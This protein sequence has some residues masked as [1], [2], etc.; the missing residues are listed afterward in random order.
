MTGGVARRRLLAA[1]G[2]ALGAPSLAFGQRGQG[3]SASCDVL[4]AGGGGA[5]LAAAVSAAQEGAR[6]ILIEKLGALGGDTMRSSGYISAVVPRL[7]AA[8]GIEDSVELHAE[9]TLKA[10]GGFCDPRIV[11]RMVASGEATVRWLQEAGVA[12]EPSVTEIYG[13]L[14][15]RCL[16]PLLPRGTG[17]IRA[18]SQKALA[19]G[20]KVLL[21]TALKELRFEG[22]RV[23]GALAESKGA[24]LEIEARRGV[25][26]ATGGFCSNKALLARYAPQYAGL[27]TDNSPG[28]TGDAVAVAERHGLQL[29]GMQWVECV[30][31]NPVGHR[32][33][34]RLFMPGDF[35]LVNAAGERF[36]AEDARRS[37]LSGAIMR[38]ARQRCFTVFDAVGESHLDAQS[39]KSLYRALVADEAYSEPDVGALARALGMPAG[40]LEA[41]ISAYNEDA[42]R[43]RGKCERLRCQ[44]LGAPPF[45]AYEVGLTLHYTAGGLKV[46]ADCRCIGRGGAPVQGLWAAGEA[47][48]S[49]HGAD[50]LGGNGLLDAFSNGKDWANVVTSLD[51]QAKLT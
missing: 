51:R 4:V 14:H 32:T 13:A 8:Q 9:Q 33:H 12:F 37:E 35:I 27:P 49:V 23:A 40:K 45:W 50:R 29:E 39:R 24:P 16:K 20:V 15:A 31:G 48:G 17:Y 19:L 18:L 2:C 28:S 41:T 44:P 34:A 30:A 5:G 43:G 47:T 25:V 10:G 3:G 1:A 21:S 46:D 22:G 7:Q 42:R 11:R 38:Q 6:V 26:I 36:V